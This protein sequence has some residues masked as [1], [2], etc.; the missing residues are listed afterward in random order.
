MGERAL[1]QLDAARVDADDWHTG[2]VI[3]YADAERI[4]RQLLDAAP[5]PYTAEDVRRVI[6]EEAVWAQS[7]GI[8]YVMPKP[9]V[10]RICERL[11]QSLPGGHA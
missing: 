11:A 8:E 2:Y 6:F 4:I 5:A 3:P 9:L 10:D 7:N 1:E